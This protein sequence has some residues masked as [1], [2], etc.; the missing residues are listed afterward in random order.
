MKP[1]CSWCSGE[2]HPMADC[3]MC[4]LPEK[5]RELLRSALAALAEWEVLKLWGGT[6]EH[7]HEFIRGQQARIHA[8]QDAEKDSARLD[9]LMDTLIAGGEQALRGALGEYD[10][11][12]RAVIDRSA[13]D[14]A[15]K[16]AKP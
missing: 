12:E 1:R 6:P 3:P 7:V 15:M 13:I 14:A 4:Q 10:D 2:P 5:T 9:W 8:V 11:A 16:K